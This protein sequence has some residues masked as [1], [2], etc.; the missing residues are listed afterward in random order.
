MDAFASSGAHRGTLDHVCSRYRCCA[1]SFAS[2]SS[3]GVL[4]RPARV[5]PSPS[6]TRRPAPRRGALP[7]QAPSTVGRGAAATRRSP[8]TTDDPGLEPWSQHAGR[9]RSSMNSSR[10]AGPLGPHELLASPGGLESGTG[11]PP[12]SRPAGCFA[13]RRCPQGRGE[14]LGPST[15][16]RHTRGSV[17]C[18][19]RPIGVTLR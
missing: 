4:P 2:I 8:T 9:R 10:N 19:A 15:S 17:S 1:M 14:T 6:A 5:G 11:S 12:K 7:G 18:C 3:L 16:P 13:L